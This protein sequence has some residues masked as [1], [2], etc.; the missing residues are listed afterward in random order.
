MT[1]RLQPLPARRL[2]AFLGALLCLLVAPVLALA[3]S[4]A[5]PETKSYESS[6]GAVRFTVTPRDLENQLRYFDDKVGGRE[7]AGQ[8][9]GS[10]RTRPQG[11]LEVRQPDGS[12]RNVWEQPLVNDVAPVSALV[13]PGGAHVVTFDN[14]HMMGL[15][16]NVVVIYDASGRPVRSLKLTD[17]LPEYVVDALPRSVSSIWWGG[18]HRF[19]D[20][21]RQLLLQ[22][23]IPSTQADERTA[24]HFE[25][26]VDLATGRPATPGGAAWDEARRGACLVGAADRAASRRQSE[27]LT[28]PSAGGEREWH[29]YLSEAFYRTDP[30]WQENA[31]MTKVL[32]SRQASDYAASLVWLREALRENPSPGD[33]RM[34][35]SPSQSHLAATLAQE[36]ARLRP[37]SLRGV[38][39]YLAL[40]D[41][42]WRLAEQALAPTGARLVQLDPARPLPQRPERMPPTT[43]RVAACDDVV[44]EA[45]QSAALL[46][47]ALL[48]A[49]AMAGALWLAQSHRGAAGDGGA[50]A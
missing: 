29:G 38:T 35:A 13:A 24:R 20:D 44:P 49:F 21:G 25:V 33:V 3:D 45:G 28:G 8:A 32:R 43:G 4:W 31:P 50:S 2:L 5:L 40:G 27:P 47:A 7:P 39:L 41:A 10:S 34:F 30:S 12:W 22:I 6:D 48:A 42:D 15:G 14:W 26:A 1:K 23:V 18:A 11:R 36:A 9:S 37:R 16:E 17:V 46:P 19:S